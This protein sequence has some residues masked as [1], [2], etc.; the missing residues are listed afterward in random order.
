MLFLQTGNDYLYWYV[1][2]YTIIL[3]TNYTKFVNSLLENNALLM[4][5]KY[6]IVVTSL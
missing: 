1:I 5:I 2:S 4:N 3:C 6:N